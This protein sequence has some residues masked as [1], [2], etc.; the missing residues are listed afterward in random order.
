LSNIRETAWN[1][2]AGEST[3]TFYTAE[4]KWIDRISGWKEEYPDEVD[5]RYTNKD[6]S[7]VAH[8]PITWFRVKPPKKMSEEQK[9]KQAAILAAHR[10]PKQ[11]Q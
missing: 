1:H 9:Q 10:K 6:G 2:I 3:G 8:L 11:S 4:Q 5:I 7:I